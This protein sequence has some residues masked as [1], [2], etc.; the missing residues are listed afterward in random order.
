MIFQVN[1]VVNEQQNR[2]GGSLGVPIVSHHK[3]SGEKQV[4]PDSLNDRQTAK[5]VPKVATP[6]M[7]LDSL[8]VQLASTTQQEKDQ[9]TLD[10][11]PQREFDGGKDI[12]A[13][14][15]SLI[16]DLISL[17]LTTLTFRII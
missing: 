1:I 4:V 15:Q 16:K 13:D 2:D 17:D 11:L 3:H 8:L 6:A 14:I 12:L 10:S 9:F 5:A 7:Q